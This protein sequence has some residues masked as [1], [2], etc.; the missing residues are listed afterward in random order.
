MMKGYIKIVLVILISCCY[1]NT[2]FEFSDTEEKVNFENESHAYIQQFS[3]QTF[4]NIVTQSI[5][6]CD[7][8]CDTLIQLHLSAILPASKCIS[9]YKNSSF[10]KPDKLFI[11]YSSFLI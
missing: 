2:V 11:L 1:V 10:P 9:S 7:I 3:N 5:P 4:A 8:N 6:H